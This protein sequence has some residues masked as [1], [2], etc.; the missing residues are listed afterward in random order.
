VLEGERR[1]KEEMSFDCQDTPHDKSCFVKPR[2]NREGGIYYNE[3]WRKG[4]GDFT[5]TTLALFM[6]E[7]RRRASALR[8]P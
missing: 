1:G 5:K 3:V 4:G 8:A 2:G 6:R 7:G